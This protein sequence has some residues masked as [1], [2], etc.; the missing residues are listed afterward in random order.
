MIINCCYVQVTLNSPDGGE[1]EVEI[2]VNN[3]DADE[4]HLLFALRRAQERRSRTFEAHQERELQRNEEGRSL[5]EKYMSERPRMTEAQGLLATPTPL[6]DEALERIRVEEG[7]EVSSP[8]R[9]FR[10][11]QDDGSRE[12]PLSASSRD[13]LARERIGRESSI[14]LGKQLVDQLKLREKLEAEQN[15]LESLKEPRGWA[16]A[17][18]SPTKQAVPR[19]WGIDVSPQKRASV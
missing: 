19:D 17:W 9:V 12:S 13:S 15:S 16:A 4:T 10:I 18:R 1:Q 5:R 3:Y 14:N 8:P 6:V 7:M 2:S 11:G